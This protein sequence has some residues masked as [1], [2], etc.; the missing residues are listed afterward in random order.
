MS[1]G[2]EGDIGWAGWRKEGREVKK[3]ERVRK[4]SEGEGE[5]KGEE[6]MVIKNGEQGKGKGEQDG[7]YCERNKK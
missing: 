2:G 1:R 3:K 5:G 4:G 7:R 6:R